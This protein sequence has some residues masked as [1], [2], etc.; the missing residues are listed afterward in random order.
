MNQ[1]TKSELNALLDA[2]EKRRTE[3]ANQT[4]EVV[5]QGGMFLS[6]FKLLRKDVIRLAMEEI[7]SELKVQGQECKISE[8][9][10]P[11]NITMSVFPGGRASTLSFFAASNREKVISHTDNLPGSQ[12]LDSHE[13]SLNEITRDV[14]ER[15]VVRFLKCVFDSKSA[16]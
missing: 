5:R 4:A 16:F 9:D 11:P 15:E 1:K 6:E 8:A 12:Q 14:I 10:D 7:G 2:H 3:Q 13:F